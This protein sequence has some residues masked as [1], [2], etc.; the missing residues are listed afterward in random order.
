MKILILANNSLGLYRFRGTLI[1]ELLK[2]GHIVYA[3][4]PR[5]DHYDDLERMGVQMLETPIDRRGT[6]P[7]A[8]VRLSRTYGRMIREVQPDL[9]LTYTIKPNV[10]GG[11]AA[12]RAG[13]PY[14]VNVT[15]LGTSFQKAGLLRQIVTVLNRRGLKRAS[16]VFFENSANCDIFCRLRIVE[17]DVCH[18][19]HGAGVD[20]ETFSATPY[21]TDDSEIRLLF[22][23]RVMKEK[24][25][26]ELFASMRR[27]REEGASCTLHIVG[28]YED[29]Y[30]DDIKKGER[31]GWLVYHGYQTDVTAFMQQ[32][33]CLVLPSYHEGMA[34]VN[35]EAAAMGRPLI[36]SRIPGCMEAVR[37][38]E[39]GFL[40]EAQDAESLYDCMNRF[41]K[42]PRADREAMG[43]AGRAYME[44]IFDKR[45]VVAET[46]EVLRRETGLQL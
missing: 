6:N 2:K 18:V 19:L 1:R 13:I 39:T 30:V 22:V 11:Y 38:G 41:L 27:L 4:T 5:N 8:D 16:V 36:T 14:A 46:L 28:D 3:S 45:K 24:G 12:R 40:C 44:E 7:L 37:E 32:A 17:K 15:G 29:N 43:M 9:I 34:N 10:Y 23:G 20:T 33:H 31:E 35:L 21:P 26:D 42:L 25:I